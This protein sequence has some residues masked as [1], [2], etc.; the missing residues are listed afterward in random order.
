MAL[1]Q[2]LLLASRLPGR[3]PMQRELIFDEFKRALRQY[4]HMGHGIIDI[5]LWDLAGKMLGASVSTL[6]GGWRSR[7]KAYASTAHGD[8]AGGLS[9]PS[10]YVNF[11]EHC[12][13][14]GYRGFKMHG[15]Y[16][17][18]VAEEAETVR[19]LGRHMGGRMELMLDPACHL[20]TF[21]DALAVGRACDDAGFFWYED[22]FRDTGVSAIAHRK[23]RELIRTPLLITEHVRGIEPKLDFAVANATDF[24]RA[25]PEYDLGITGMMKIAHAAEAMGLDVEIHGSGPAHRHCMSAIRNT[26]FYEVALVGPKMANPLP[27][28]YVCGYTDNLEGVG[29]DGCFPVPTGD[30]LGV[31]YDWDFIA[32]H[33]T[34]L[35]EYCE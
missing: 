33:R 8:R 2:T 5:A 23:L 21:A 13:S 28:V 15:W 22:P 31:E 11:A 16:E 4:D 27:P 10:D 19:A 9:S 30:G 1:G 3:D 26:N 17:G 20:R 24:L 18:N 14:L 7:L 29:E 32:R 12:Y 34:N 25:D 6:L 35:H